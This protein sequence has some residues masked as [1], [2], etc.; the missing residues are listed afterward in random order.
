VPIGP[1]R[2]VF[3]LTETGE[4]DLYRNFEMLA[5]N[6]IELKEC[7]L[8]VSATFD[9]AEPDNTRMAMLGHRSLDPDSR[10]KLAHTL[11]LTL[12]NRG[13]VLT[14]LCWDG[15]WCVCHAQCPRTHSDLWR[16]TC[17]HLSFFSQM[18]IFDTFLPLHD[19]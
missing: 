1:A 7:T 6:V 10:T 12:L 16:A 2:D 13:P 19:S 18:H 5:H 9:T 11:Q 15:K 14:A 3:D 4:Y 17:T 8:L